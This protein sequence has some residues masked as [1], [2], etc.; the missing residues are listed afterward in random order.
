MSSHTPPPCVG[1]V[2]GVL[3]GTSMAA[4]LSKVVFLSRGPHSPGFLVALNVSSLRPPPT[5][6]GWA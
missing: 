4:G 5:A 6:S 1:P 3:T 2:S